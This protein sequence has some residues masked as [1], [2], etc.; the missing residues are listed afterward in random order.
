MYMMEYYS[1]LK[2]WNSAICDNVNGLWRHYL[3]WNKWNRESQIMCD[4]IHIWNKKIS[5]QTKPNKIK[6]IDTENR[7]AVT[8]GK[9]G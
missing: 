2:R 3:K 5:G 6:H 7:V 4:F 9:E 8:R 1:A